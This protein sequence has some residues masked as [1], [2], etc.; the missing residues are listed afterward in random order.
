MKLF[1][2]EAKNIQKQFPD[3]F[4]IKRTNFLLDKGLTVAFL[5]QNGAGK[6]TL[7]QML[8]G[9][10]EL[11]S[12]EIYIDQELV[13]TENF[14]VKKKIGYLPQNPC[15]PKWVSGIEI[16]RYSAS[17]HDLEDPEDRI[18]KS[19]LYWD[20]ESFKKLPLEVCSHGMQKRIGLA[21]A[22]LNDPNYLILDEPFSGLDLHHVYCLEKKII[23][24]QKKGQLT[25]ISTHIA[26]YVAKLCQTVFMIRSGSIKKI[27]GWTEKNEIN[28]VEMIRNQFEK[29]NSKIS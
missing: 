10:L 11:S 21:I 23:E 20:C 12:G 13:T 28:R 27:K 18:N 3:G 24:R 8:T 1:K 2:M 19:L 7:F 6:S 14:L 25:I 15:L 5:G 17:L 9:N 26:P 16:L 22:F 4:S 29:K